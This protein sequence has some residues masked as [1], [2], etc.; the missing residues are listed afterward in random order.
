MSNWQYA[1][2]TPADTFRGQMTLP[3]ELSL[4]QKTGEIHLAQKII[5]ELDSYTGKLFFDKENIPVKSSPFV[6]P[7]IIKSMACVLELHIKNNRSLLDIIFKNNKEERIEIKCD[8]LNKTFSIDRSHSGSTGF[9][10]HFPG[11]HT[12]PFIEDVPGT[13]GFKIYF[14]ST[15]VELITYDGLLSVTELIFPSEPFSQF[16][17]TA[18]G[19]D[20]LIEKIILRGISNEPAPVK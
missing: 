3:R 15:S 5:R 16:I 10:R 2:K 6:I 1:A 9:S 18:P 13:V 20:V 12:A 11:V 14:D 19:N 8:M 4:T 17:L 7:E